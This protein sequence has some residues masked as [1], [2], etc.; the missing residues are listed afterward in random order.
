MVKGLVTSLFL[1]LILFY[2]M[3]VF[4]LKDFIKLCLSFSTNRTMKLCMQL[5][6]FSFLPPFAYF[7]TSG[8]FVS[9]LFYACIFL[10]D[11]MYS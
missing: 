6:L 8:M 1:L 7:W 4:L 2:F 9:S 3:I 10:L 5:I 11:F